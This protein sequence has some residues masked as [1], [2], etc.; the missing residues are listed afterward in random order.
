MIRLSAHAQ[1]GLF[2]SV[3]LVAGIVC[4]WHDLP[5]STLAFGVGAGSWLGLF[6]FTGGEE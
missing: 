2:A 3:S 1:S 4:A 5:W 6:V